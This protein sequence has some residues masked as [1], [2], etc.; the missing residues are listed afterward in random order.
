MSVDPTCSAGSLLALKKRTDASKKCW[1]TDPA[2]INNKSFLLGQNTI[3]K[4]HCIFGE[5]AI[6]SSFDAYVKMTRIDIERCCDLIGSSMF[7]VMDRIDG[8]VIVTQLG[9]DVLDSRTDVPYDVFKGAYILDGIAPFQESNLLFPSTRNTKVSILLSASKEP[10]RLFGMKYFVEALHRMSL[11]TKPHKFSCSVKYVVPLNRYENN[12]MEYSLKD[13]GASKG[14]HMD[15]CKGVERVVLS[16]DEGIDLYDG[17]IGPLMTGP[18]T[19]ALMFS[20]PDLKYHHVEFDH[21]PS[22]QLYLYGSGHPIITSDTLKI[23]DYSSLSFSY[24][25]S[26]EK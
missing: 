12:R 24:S 21:H 13:I 6:T 18:E 2:V 5:I 20:N 1:F 25:I 3:D 19:A 11:F 15:K 17:P 26:L 22:A 9:D 16:L 14:I 23:V 4:V 8:L 10:P 7:L